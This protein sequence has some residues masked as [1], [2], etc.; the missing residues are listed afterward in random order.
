MFVGVLFS[1]F[2]MARRKKSKHEKFG[3]GRLKWVQ[4]QQKIL[5]EKPYDIHVTKFGE[6]SY[7]NKILYSEIFQFILKLGFLLNTIIVFFNFNN[8]MF[9]SRI[10]YY[11]SFFI[12]FVYNIEILLKIFVYGIFA[13]FKNSN[14]FFHLFMNLGFTIN[15]LFTFHFRKRIMNFNY[16]EQ[17]KR[18]LN[19][20]QLIAIIRLISYSKTLKTMLK[21]MELSY[22][23]LLNIFAIFCLIL[24]SFAIIG[25]HFFKYTMSTLK[26]GNVINNYVN[27][28][29]VFTAMLTLFKITT[30]D[31]AS[32]IL[33]EIQ[34]NSQINICIIIFVN[35]LKG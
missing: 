17:I 24:F 9:N 26:E 15:F 29:N 7:L 18:I 30:S 23:L 20:F 16:G 28:Q 19:F 32:E 21:T 6:K 2:Q 35:F 5:E 12:C 13:F 4:I 3:P 33:F 22:S 25:C 27:F 10:I 11:F 14:F 1:N 31:G 34:N 8:T